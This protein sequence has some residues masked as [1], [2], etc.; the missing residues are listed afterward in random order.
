MKFLRINNKLS[1]GLGETEDKIFDF[2]QDHK[3]GVLATVDPNNMPHASVLFYTI[4]KTFAA[5]FLTKKGTRKS[6]NLRHNNHAMLLIYDEKSQTTAQITGIVAEIKDNDETHQVFL[7]AL[8]A[9]LHTA[10]SAIPPISRV[11]AGEYVAYELKPAEVKMN[12]Y[13]RGVLERGSG[14]YATLRVPSLNLN[15]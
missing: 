7:N 4:D 12:V 1:H 14:N 9:S 2:L 15:T 8:R 6:D 10:E 11:D 3:T 5:R 13:K